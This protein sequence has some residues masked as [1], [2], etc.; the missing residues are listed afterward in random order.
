MR[1]KDI[2]GQEK[3]K[4]RLLQSVAENRVSHA[5]L[6]IGPNGVG[7]LSLAIAFGQYLSCTNR[8]DT[9]SCGVCPSCKKYEKLIHPD[10]HFV[11]PVFSSPKFS[12][13]I[14]DNF[15]GEWREIINSN[16][17][18]SLNKWLEYIGSENKQGIISTHESGQIIKKLNLKAF[19]SEYKVMI[20][21][22]PE[23]MN[24]TASNKLLKMIEEPPPKTIFLLVS[25]D[26][27]QLLKTIVTRTQIIAVPRIDATSLNAAIIEKYSLCDEESANIVRLS[28]GSYS[29]ANEIISH[30]E[31]SQE[32]FERFTSYMRLLYQKDVISLNKW[33]DEIATIGREKQKS[34]L[35]YAMRLIRDNFM[36][37]QNANELAFTSNEETEFSKKFSPFIKPENIIQINEELNTAY[38]HI[39]R[40]GYAKIVF[41]DLG[42]KLVVLLKT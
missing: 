25:E 3:T 12:Q 29:R 31:S 9:D 7:K 24:Q 40:N 15:I 28:E 32:N 5:Q 38:Y 18:I 1:F 30:N 11:F 34:F 39:E 19:E 13:A 27:N 14:S 41:F 21:W 26:K 22:M 2:I 17:Y 33:V 8:S 23:K 4:K 20:I 36:L 6:I 10:L 42:L 16:P 35:K 37:N